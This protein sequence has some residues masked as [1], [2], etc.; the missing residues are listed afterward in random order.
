MSK[1]KN[2][3]VQFREEVTSHLNA[4][5]KFGAGSKAAGLAKPF[6]ADQDPKPKNAVEAAIPAITQRRGRISHE[7]EQLEAAVLDARHRR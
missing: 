6:V 1:P 2:S 3:V 5:R 7:T 4:F